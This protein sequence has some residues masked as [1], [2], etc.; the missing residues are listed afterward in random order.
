MMSQAKFQNAAA[1][2]DR[3]AQTVSNAANAAG[4]AVRDATAQ[5]RETASDI[6]ARVSRR[7]DDAVGEL[8]RRVEQ[9][10]ISSILIAG[11]VGLLTG[12]LLARR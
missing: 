10:P 11:G 9:Q 8:A 2:E 6:G 3:A 5:F 4:A 12:L 1:V 7:A